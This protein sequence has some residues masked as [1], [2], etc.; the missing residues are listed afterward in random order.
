MLLWREY[1]RPP[2][3][4]VRIVRLKWCSVLCAFILGATISW[5][6]RGR[7]QHNEGGT[8]APSTQPPPSDPEFGV[9]MATARDPAT[10][11]PSP[12][13]QQQGQYPTGQGQPQPP[14]GQAQSQPSATSSIPQTQTQLP[15][16][17]QLAAPGPHPQVLYE[18][19]Q[20]PKY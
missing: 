10:V 11:I 4:L 6:F 20:L 16:Y 12:Q 14:V 9:P 2:F 19:P 5:I 18:V 7:H 8:A 13:G 3:C 17:D 15:V 1:S